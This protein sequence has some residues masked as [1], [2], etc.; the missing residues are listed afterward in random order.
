M[1][2]NDKI[3]AWRVH[4]ALK[5]AGIRLSPRTCGGLLALN[6]RLYNQA[7]FTP[8]SQAKKSMPFRAAYRHEYWTVDIRYVDYTVEYQPDQKHFW[9]VTALRMYDTQYRSPQLRLWQLGDHEWLKVLR[10]LSRVVRKQRVQSQVVQE[11][12]FA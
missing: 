4:A 1:G 10:L 8:P 7:Q 9:A 11:H 3:G 2:Y 5:Q 6:R 12:L